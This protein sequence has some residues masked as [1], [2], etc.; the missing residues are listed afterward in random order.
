MKLTFT[1]NKEDFLTFQLFTASKSPSLQKARRMN[2]WVV[3]IMYLVVALIFYF[4]DSPQYTLGF[5]ILAILWAI[6]FP[7]FQSWRQ[8]VAYEKFIQ[9]HLK[10]RFDKL[11]QITFLKNSLHSKDV[12]GEG[13]MPFTEIEEISEISTHYFIKFKAG[14][15]LILPKKELETQEKVGGHLRNLADKLQFKYNEELEWR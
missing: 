7:F 12:S 6:F 4:L 5:I 15:H 3:P 14:V 1:L 2:L 11:V 8:R 13:S 10:E 9:E